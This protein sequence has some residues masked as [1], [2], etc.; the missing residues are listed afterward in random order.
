MRK[1]F[2]LSFMMYSFSIYGQHQINNYKY[3]IVN[4]RFDFV[5][6]VDGY[7]TSSLTKFLFNKF[8]YTA[9]LNSDNLP[10]G[11]NKDRCTALFV[12]IKTDPSF[13]KTKIIIELRN[14][15]NLLIYKSKVGESREKDYKKAYHEAIRDAFK[16]KILVS[17]KYTKNKVPEASQKVIKK[18]SIL[19]L[20]TKKQ[21]KL[22]DINSGQKKAPVVYAKVNKDGYLLVNELSKMTFKVLKTKRENVFI[23][24][25]KNGILYKKD[26]NWI[27]E[28]YDNN[29]LV[30][31]VYQVKF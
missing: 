3:I 31:K 28:Y 24:K 22:S 30:K 27:A 2:F 19:Q 17:Y 26:A 13:F 29:I 7:Q 9:F 10:E 8:G 23:I 21:I 15:S 16:D 11:F 25:N 4:N 18:D 1:I 14:C 12:N 5:N 6:D 20:K